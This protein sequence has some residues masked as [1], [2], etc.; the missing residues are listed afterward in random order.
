MERHQKG[1]Q[2]ERF[3]RSGRA[4]YWEFKGIRNLS[5]GLARTRGICTI[6]TKRNII[7]YFVL[8]LFY[9]RMSTAMAGLAEPVPEVAASSRIVRQPYGAKRRAQADSSFGLERGVQDHLGLAY[10]D[11]SMDNGIVLI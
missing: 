8:Q 1:A 5:L 10:K 2:H 4:S 6:A 11:C 7:S 3:A 9:V